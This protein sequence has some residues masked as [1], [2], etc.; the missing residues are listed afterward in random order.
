MASQVD[1]RADM[2]VLS[3]SDDR[4]VR[5]WRRRD[6]SFDCAH[7]LRGHASRHDDII[8]H[9]ASSVQRVA[10]CLSVRGLGQCGR[11]RR[12]C[13]LA[14]G[15]VA[16]APVGSFI[17]VLHKCSN[18]DRHVGHVGSVRAVAVSPSGR[19][20]TGHLNI[21]RRDHNMFRR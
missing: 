14:P 12:L 13:S 18:D 1:W 4:S 6:V 17:T 15:R 10:V 16:R 20:V 11:G 3:A 9:I 19:I 5:V 7:V 21:M 8:R 2:Q